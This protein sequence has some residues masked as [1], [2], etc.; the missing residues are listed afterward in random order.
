ML[1]SLSHCTVLTAKEPNCTEFRALA[2]MASAKSTGALRAWSSQAGDGYRAKVVFA[3][4][5]FEL[6]PSDIRSASAVLG[7][8]PRND[9][10]DI[11][12]QSLIYGLDCDARTEREVHTLAVLEADLPRDLARAVLLVPDKMLAYISYANI[13]VGDPHS[14]YAVQMQRVSRAK[15]REFANAVDRLTPDDKKW[16]LSGTFN[17]DGCR[18]LHFTEE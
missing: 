10:Q 3:A 7:L 13:S 9:E 4:R 18:A 14:D 17:P 2:G 12:W 16:F 6:H 8:I 15:H 1:A 11:V 5:L